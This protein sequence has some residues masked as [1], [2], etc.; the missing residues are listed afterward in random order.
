MTER[1][2]TEEIKSSGDLKLAAYNTRMAELFGER[3][4]YP[5]D[6]PERTAAAEK[7]LAH[8]WTEGD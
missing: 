5:V 3:D 4:K 7:I 6:S 2:E 1:N 8:W